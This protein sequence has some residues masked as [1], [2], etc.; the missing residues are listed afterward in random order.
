M[1]SR[2]ILATMLAL[3]ISTSFAHSAGPLKEQREV[4]MKSIGSSMGVLVG[5]AKGKAPYDGEQVKAALANMSAVSKKFPE[6]FPSADAVED[7]AASPKIWE[8]FEDFKAKANKL[9]ADAET[10]LAQLPAD[11]A[12]VGA[13]LK[14]IGAN[15][16]ACHETYRIQD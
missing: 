2:T 5:I 10:L 4:T 13:S 8:N 12:A 9:S 3:A 14:V 15:C 7:K 11:Q 6:F 1:Q 16:S